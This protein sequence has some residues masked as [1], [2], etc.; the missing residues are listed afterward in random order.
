MNANFSAICFL[1]ILLSWLAVPAFAAGEIA[2]PA[3]PQLPAIR[4]N[5]AGHYLETSDGQPFFWLA[6]TGW[7]MTGRLTRAEASYYLRARARQG[8]T[9]VQVMVLPENDLARTNALGE[10][11][12]FENDPARPNEKYFDRVVELVDEAAANGLYLALLP[13]WGD[14]LTAPWGEG[15]R[16]FR[17]DN[18]PAVRAYAKYLGGKMKGKSNVV[19]MLGG[20]RPAKLDGRRPEQWPQTGGTA[21][22]FPADYDWTPVWR[23]FAAG[24][25]EG[26]GTSPVFL[27]H[28]QGGEYRTSKTLASEPWLAIH[29][30][31]SGHGGGHD[32]PV[33]D[34]VAQDYALKPAKPVLDLEQNYEDHPYNPWPRWDPATG[35]FRDHDV[36]KQAYRSVFAGAAGVTYGH[37]AVWQFAGPRYEVINFADRDWINALYRPG[38]SQVV[39]LRQLI[40][41]R[42][43]FS[44]VPD[45][46]LIVGDAGKGG[47]HLQA[48]RD[49]EG[50]YAFV[51]FPLNDQSATIDLGKLNARIVRAWWYDPRTGVGTLLGEFDGGGRRE[52]R[53]PP[54][55]P[56]W[57]LV[58][59]DAAKNYP[60]P[61]LKRSW[62]PLN[63]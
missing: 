22:G 19:W 44:R 55:G 21:A 31:Q 3:M 26:T 62:R 53:T 56:D 32:Q 34:W 47:F 45:P 61:G 63:R 11:A 23:E 58:L 41:S 46:L 20:D 24:I 2:T 33:W 50:T 18:L 57:V 39:F 28:P 54:T 52:F 7:K 38:A 10:K 9:V 59:D 15:P 5:P 6:D 12:F 30:M 42:P 37:H 8:F 16:V 13:A 1:S 36:R 40:E 4:V 27:Y 29:G 14:Q 35:F 51:Y 60:P 48:T 17:N 25:A 43:F 49:R